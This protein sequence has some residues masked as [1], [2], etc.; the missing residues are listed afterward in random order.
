MFIGNSN[1]YYRHEVKAVKMQSSYL[2]LF[3]TFCFVF[4]NKSLGHKRT[5][6]VSLF[7][8]IQLLI[9]EAFRVLFQSGSKWV[10]FAVCFSE[11]ANAAGFVS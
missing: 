5:G 10:C 2:I 7:P 1:W 3:G 9:F 11:P 8:F 4:F 6:M